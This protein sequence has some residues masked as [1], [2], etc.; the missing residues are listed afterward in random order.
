MR[1]GSDGVIWIVIAGLMAVIAII[2]TSFPSES[3]ARTI[4]WS[5]R[6][7]HGHLHQRWLNKSKMPTPATIVRVKD[8]TTDCGDWKGSVRA[9]AYKEDGRYTISLRPMVSKFQEVMT[10]YHEVGHVFDWMYLTDENRRWFTSLFRMSGQTWYSADVD[11]NAVTGERSLAT[12]SE[13]FADLYMECSYYTRGFIKFY[14]KDWTTY[15]I[16]GPRLKM[17][18]CRY[19]ERIFR[20]GVPA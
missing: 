20:R 8:T 5:D 12:P 11:V 15:G 10:L 4:A 9:C 2:A 7:Y 19:M 3:D 14:G 13:A 16:W 6:G 17:K 18:G 1:N